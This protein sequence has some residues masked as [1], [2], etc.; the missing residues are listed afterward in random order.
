MLCQVRDVLLTRVDAPPDRVTFNSSS[1]NVTELALQREI[2]ET[3]RKATERIEKRNISSTGT[4]GGIGSKERKA[5]YEKEVPYG[6]EKHRQS[7]SYQ[8]QQGETAAFDGKPIGAKMTTKIGVIR[9][10]DV[11][12]PLDESLIYDE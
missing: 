3:E 6:V 1:G 11:I 7:A 10:K 8:Q 5:E 12:L 9:L 4:G 2:R